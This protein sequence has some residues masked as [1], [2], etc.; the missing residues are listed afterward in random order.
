[1]AF[2]TGQLA[3]VIEVTV[4]W[5]PT[6]EFLPNSFDTAVQTSNLKPV[7]HG[8]FPGLCVVGITRLHLICARSGQSNRCIAAP[9]PDRAHGFPW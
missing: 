9:I 3:E 1:M 6:L 5:P 4:T 2:M 8:H 7:F